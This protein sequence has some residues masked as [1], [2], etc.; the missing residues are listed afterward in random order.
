M[1]FKTFWRKKEKQVDKKADI[2]NQF[3]SFK[4]K[5]SLETR[6]VDFDMMGHLNNSIY[7]TYLEIARTKYW[8]HAIN[9]DW[10]KTGVVIAKA[11]VDY[12]T[13]IFLQDKVIVYVRT[14]R[15]GR[16]SFD[17]EYL[18]VKLESGKEVL[19]SKGKTVCVAYDH[20]A[21]NV[22]TI[23]TTEREKMIAFEQLTE[24]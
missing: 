2:I 10:K 20:S 9:W 5:T 18:I 3:D 21:K 11:S 22:T 1:I 4:Y 13:P 14:S 7:F 17:L 8:H 12:I 16:S 23:P 15:I 24:I 19:C 6:F